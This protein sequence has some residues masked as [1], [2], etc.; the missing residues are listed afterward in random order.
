M[1][2][3]ILFEPISEYKRVNL[4]NRL[5]DFALKVWEILIVLPSDEFTRN[6]K[7]Q[8]ARSSTS[9]AFNYGEAQSAESRKDFVHKMQ[10]C[11]KELRETLVGLKFIERGKYEVS[12]E[13]IEY[14]KKENNELIAIFVRSIDTAKKNM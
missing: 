8:L 5:I 11:L 7:G 13:K 1:D 3:I 9:P 4:E 10:I 2:D 6:L 12:V 14:L